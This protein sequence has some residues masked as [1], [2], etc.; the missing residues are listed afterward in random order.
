MRSFIRDTFNLVHGCRAGK[1]VAYAVQKSSDAEYS[2][3]LTIFAYYL[4]ALLITYVH[5]SDTIFPF[6]SRIFSLQLLRSAW[7]IFS[8]AYPHLLLRL[9]HPRESM[10]FHYW[11]SYWARCG[12][13]FG[14]TS[15]NAFSKGLLQLCMPNFAYVLG[16]FASVAAK[17]YVDSSY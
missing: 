6:V 11:E 12:A 14:N 16:Q 2:G 13:D 4:D 3:G 10:L 8:L 9:I 5:C 1:N 15:I 7:R 17:C